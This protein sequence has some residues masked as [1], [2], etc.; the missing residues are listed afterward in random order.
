MDADDELPTKFFLHGHSYG[1]Y[2]SSLYACAN[3]HRISALFLNSPAGPEGVP[4]DYNIYKLRIKT[5]YQ[6][7]NHPK[8]IDYWNSK[9]DNLETPLVIGRKFPIFL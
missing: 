6:E 1:G 9:W 2:I 5:N 7:P 8:E 4:E 3:P